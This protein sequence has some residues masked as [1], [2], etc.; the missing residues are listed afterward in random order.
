MV[1]SRRVVG[2]SP[3]AIGIVGAAISEA[4]PGPAAATGPFVIV[5]AAFRIFRGSAHERDERDRQLEPGSSRP[6]DFTDLVK[7]AAAQTPCRR[8][9]VP[10]DDRPESGRPPRTVFT[11]PGSRSRH[12]P[13]HARGLRLRPAS[14]L[15]MVHRAWSGGAQ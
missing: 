15:R 11:L 14:V 2:R 3:L 8:F 4:L 13:Q 6:D 10:P 7:Y 9:H 1:A 5:I 12:G